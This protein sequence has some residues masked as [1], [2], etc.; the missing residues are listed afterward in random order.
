MICK[1]IGKIKEEQRRLWH[2]LVWHEQLSDRAEWVPPTCCLQIVPSL[3][4]ILIRPSV[5]QAYQQFNTISHWMPWAVNLVVHWCNCVLLIGVKWSFLL[6][7]SRKHLQNQRTCKFSSRSP[8][9]C[10]L[11]TVAA[12]GFTGVRWFIIKVL[13]LSISLDLLGVAAWVIAISQPCSQGL[14]QDCS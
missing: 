14:A 2:H 9:I 10:F 4:T 6:L 5:I 1:W 13:I 7:W 11:V 3:S 12:P 8:L